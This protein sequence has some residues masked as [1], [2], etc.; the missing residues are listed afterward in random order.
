MLHIPIRLSVSRVEGVC[1]WLKSAASANVVLHRLHRL[2][3]RYLCRSWSI[4]HGTHTYNRVLLILAGL[5]LSLRL[6]TWS[7]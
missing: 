5:V 4:G 1:P 6:Q 3:T 2:P 7:R